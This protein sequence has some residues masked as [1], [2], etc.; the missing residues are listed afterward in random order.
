[1]SLPFKLLIAL[2][3]ILL[4]AFLLL[5]SGSKVSYCREV[6]KRDIIES[7]KYQN[8]MDNLLRPDYLEELT[9]GAN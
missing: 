2:G 7:K 8:E 1:M 6:V 5:N 3:A 4:T 9:R